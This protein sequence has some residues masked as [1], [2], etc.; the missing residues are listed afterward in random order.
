MSLAY[1]PPPEGRGAIADHQLGHGLPLAAALGCPAFFLGHRH[2]DGRAFQLLAAGEILGR[3]ITGQRVTAAA[4][5]KPQR[6][7]PAAAVHHRNDEAAA[8]T[9]AAVD[10]VQSAASPERADAHP[11]CNLKR[12]QAVGETLLALELRRYQRAAGQCLGNPL[13]ILK[14]W[15]PENTEPVG[16]VVMS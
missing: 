12:H 2:R 10:H 11:A 14:G 4:Q 9:G 8:P 16:W 1:R 5:L 13:R 15:M 7:E 3:R 6:A